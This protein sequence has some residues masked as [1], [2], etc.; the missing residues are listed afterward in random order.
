MNAAYSSSPYFQFYFESFEKVI[1]VKTDFL[2]DLNMKLT[3]LVLEMLK[4]EKEIIYTSHFQPLTGDENDFRYKIS[5]KIGSGF[6]A[7][8]YLQVFGNG[9]GFDNRLSIIDLIFNLGPDAP[10]YLKQDFVAD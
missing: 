8:R 5:P 7:G 10:D 1:S 2:L 9:T 4:F 3:D 6:R